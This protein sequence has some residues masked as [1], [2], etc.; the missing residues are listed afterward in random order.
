MDTQL[1]P[2]ENKSSRM[3]KSYHDHYFVVTNIPMNNSNTILLIDALN[4]TNSKYWD[5]FF[6]LQ[7]NGSSYDISVRGPSSNAAF[8]DANELRQYILLKLNLCEAK[9][10]QRN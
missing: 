4:D 5:G 7:A 10:K 1:I 6:S 9:F 8:N 3:G 2:V